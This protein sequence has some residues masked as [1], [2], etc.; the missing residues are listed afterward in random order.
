MEK[1]KKEFSNAFDESYLGF[2]TGKV[3]QSIRK[4]I[5]PSLSKHDVESIT[6]VLV[7]HLMIE[8]R[9]NGLIIK[10]LTDHLPKMG[11][12]NKKGVPVNDVAREEIEEYV[13][14]MDFS[15]T[16]GIRTNWR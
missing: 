6:I 1:N 9:I 11:S 13:K 3:A 12:M 2:P 10:W 7:S 8:E 14:K 16:R 5:S 15:L 4:I